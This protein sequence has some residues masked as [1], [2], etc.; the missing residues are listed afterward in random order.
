MSAKNNNAMYVRATGSGSPVVFVHGAGGSG[1]LFA[2]QFQAFRDDLRCY[3]VDLP[4]HGKSPR[5]GEPTISGYAQAAAEFIQT[6]GS[7]VSLVGQSMGGAIAMEL[8]L[9]HRELVERLVLVGTGCRLPVSEMILTGLEND[10]KGTTEKIVRYCFSKNAKPDLLERARREM[11]RMSPEIVRAD[12]RSCAGFDACARLSELAIPTLIICGSNDVMTP[13]HLSVQ[14]HGL[15]ENSQLELISDG[16]HMVMLEQ[17]S[18]FNRL[19]LQFLTLAH[20]SRA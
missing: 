9:E 16:S 2:N 3:F 18:M 19:V 14:L 10:Y 15:I 8:A 6:L 5:T 13:Q 4:G 7:P 11:A 17:P 1:Q 20:P 12:V